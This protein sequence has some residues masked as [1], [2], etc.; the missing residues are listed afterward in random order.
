MLTLSD[1]NRLIEAAFAEAAR[2]QLKP[3]T[4]AVLDAGGT[5]LAFQ[6]QGTGVVLAR[7][8]IAIGKARITLAQGTASSRRSADTALQRPNFTQGLLAS[9]GGPLMPVPGG[10]AITGGGTVVG[11][12]GISGDTS[13]NDEAVAMASV[14]AIGREA[15][16]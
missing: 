5:L 16:V 12:V 14:Q 7:P 2:R 15:E 1:A 4:V 10:L 8:E 9:F 6:R 3:L 11:A 13:D